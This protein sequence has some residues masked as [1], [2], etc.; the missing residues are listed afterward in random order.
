MAVPNR[1]DTSM[2]VKPQAVRFIYSLFS[3]LD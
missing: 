1:N 3:F 2:A